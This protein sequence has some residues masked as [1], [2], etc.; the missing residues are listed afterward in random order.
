MNMSKMDHSE[1]KSA[2]WFL[3]LS[4]FTLILA[5]IFF[6]QHPIEQRFL[7]FSNTFFESFFNNPVPFT[8][9]WIFMSIHGLMMSGVLI[10]LFLLREKTVLRS[11]QLFVGLSGYLFLMLTYISRIYY[12]NDIGSSYLVADSATQTV[13]ET[14]GLQEFDWFN[15]AFGFPAIWFVVF[16]VE[17]MARKNIYLSMLSA[18]V[19]F[20]YVFSVVGYLMNVSLMITIA[21]SMA[22]LFLLVWL[23]IVYKSLDRLVH[24]T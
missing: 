23:I 11:W 9:F 10:S 6:K 18:L 17:M 12:I 13:I 19:G 24:D 20:G 22:F 2:R 15:M 8:G 4:A 1:L 3:L 7:I 21:S 16:S 14:Y 5:I